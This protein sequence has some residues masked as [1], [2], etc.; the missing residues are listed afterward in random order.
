MP[1]TDSS[2]IYPDADRYWRLVRKT[3]EEVFGK[4]PNSVGP[5]RRDVGTSPPDEQ[6][7]FYHAEP[8][9]VAADLA[10][11]GGITEEHVKKYRQIANGFKW[12]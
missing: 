5:L 9:D 6:W 7:S 3:L 2:P 8:L 4:N 12:R 1:T 11:I 10:G